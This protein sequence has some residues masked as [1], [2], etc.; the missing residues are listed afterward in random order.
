V[1]Q[2]EATHHQLGCRKDVVLLAYATLPVA[3]TLLP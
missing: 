3:S 2:D 1:F